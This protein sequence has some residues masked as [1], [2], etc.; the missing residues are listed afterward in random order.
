[1]WYVYCLRCRDGSYY[2]GVTPDPKRRLAQHNAGKGGA[3]TRS[4][5]PVRMAVL[6][7][8]PDRSSAQSR[9]AEIKRWPREKKRIRW[10]RARRL[11]LP[12]RRPGCAPR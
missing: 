11:T 10:S 5:R 6:E 3:Y 1:M 4:R 2:T 7:T 8:R 9:E 12:P